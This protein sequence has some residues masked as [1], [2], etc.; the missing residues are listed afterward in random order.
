MQLC[1]ACFFGVRFL[2]LEVFFVI[3]HMVDESLSATTTLG[4]CFS[5]TKK[6]KDASIHLFQ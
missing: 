2:L 4:Y 6:G 3:G 1:N 5:S